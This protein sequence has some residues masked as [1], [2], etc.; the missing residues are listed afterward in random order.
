MKP[1]ARNVA[2]TVVVLLAGTWIA[3]A[4]V[5]YKYWAKTFRLVQSRDLCAAIERL[6][7]PAN[8]LVSHWGIRNLHGRILS[9]FLSVMADV[10]S[11]T[12]MIHCCISAVLE[13][14]GS[15]DDCGGQLRILSEALTHDFVR[16]NELQNALSQF[17]AHISNKTCSEST[18][19]LVDSIQERILTSGVAQP[20]KVE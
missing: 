12:Q 7:R 5:E 20:E 10:Q 9:E 16:T 3:L 4:V 8:K 19:R 15:L 13:S 18:R 2:L 6:G 11:N 17:D 14:K 1:N